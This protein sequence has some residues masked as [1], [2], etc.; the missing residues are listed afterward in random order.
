MEKNSGKEHG[1]AVGTLVYVHTHTHKDKTASLSSLGETLGR[2]CFSCRMEQAVSTLRG[3]LCAQ[4][5]LHVGHN[6]PFLPTWIKATT[7]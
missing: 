5:Y 3:Q 4:F 7:E 1:I 6:V 2:D